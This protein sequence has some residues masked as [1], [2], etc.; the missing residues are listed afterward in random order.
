MFHAT[1]FHIAPP[2][3]PAKRCMMDTWRCREEAALD[4]VAVCRRNV[5]D[6]FFRKD[7]GLVFDLPNF[8]C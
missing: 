8:M 5:H 7:N 4:A 1:L 2:Q 6:I 3:S